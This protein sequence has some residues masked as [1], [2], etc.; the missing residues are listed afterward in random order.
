MGAVERTS[1]LIT[2]AL[3][4]FRATERISFSVNT[5]R[6]WALFEPK[7]AYMAK[8][9]ANFAISFA[10]RCSTHYCLPRHLLGSWI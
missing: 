10:L 9:S 4:D 3:S 2:D 7:F 1:A 8:P 5:E 6:N